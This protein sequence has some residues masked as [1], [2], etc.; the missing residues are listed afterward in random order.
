MNQATRRISLLWTSPA[1]YTLALARHLKE[2]GW[3]LQLFGKPI[4]SQSPY[5][6]LDLSMFTEAYLAEKPSAD[7][8]IERLE[9]FKPTVVLLAKWSDNSYRRAL[10]VV[11]AIGARVIACMDNQW[12]GS[13]RQRFGCVI[14]PLYL[15]PVIDN[16][17]VAGDRQAEFA[18]RLGYQN[19]LYGYYS[20]DTETFQCVPEISARP[21]AFIFVGRLVP[22]KGI[23]VL[24]EA[25]TSYRRESKRPW[26]LR[27]AGTGPLQGEVQRTQGVEYLGFLEP[28]MLAH[29]FTSARCLVLPSRVEPWGVV[30]HEATSSGLAV[31]ASRQCGATTSFVRDGVNGILVQ[32]GAQAELKEAMM[33]VAESEE[34]V[35]ESW[36]RASVTMARLWSPRIAA[37]Y[38]ESR[39]S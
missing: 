13:V 12:T 30:I 27:V 19:P 32:A 16:L 26:P 35:L 24:L 17:W 38:L 6:R 29:E 1:T 14:A 39:L 3:A 4:S 34:T 28:E 25:Y 33:R 8:L 20:A 11:K 15:H 36:S 31:I 22:D 10:P 9:S 21:R 7:E 37:G 23:D 18:A 5:R 2:R